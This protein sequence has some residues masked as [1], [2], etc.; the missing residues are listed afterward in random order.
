MALA[1]RLYVAR[2]EP[3]PTVLAVILR[4]AGEKVLQIVTN[5]FILGGRFATFAR[6]RCAAAGATAATKEKH[7]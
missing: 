1:K 5:P 6:A 7:Q 4:V 2:V 3:G